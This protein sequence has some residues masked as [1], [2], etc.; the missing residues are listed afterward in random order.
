MPF[1]IAVMLYCLYHG[2]ASIVAI[3]YA[4]AILYGMQYTTVL[5]TRDT[6]AIGV[7]CSV[8]IVVCG[9]IVNKC[10]DRAKIV[11]CSVVVIVLALS[12]LDLYCQHALPIQMVL[13]VVLIG[14]VYCI[15]H[16]CNWCGCCRSDNWCLSNSIA[17]MS[18]VCI[19]G[20][21]LMQLRSIYVVWVAAIGVVIL[22]S[23]SCNVLY[24][25]QVQ[26]GYN[27]TSI[28]ISSTMQPIG[29]QQHSVVP[30][31]G[32]HQD[33]VYNIEYCIASLAKGG[34]SGDTCQVLYKDSKAYLVLSDGMGNG[35]SANCASCDTVCLIEDL[36]QHGYDIPQALRYVN[37]L[38]LSDDDMYATL[39]IVDINLNTGKVSISKNGTPTTILM[40]NRSINI[41]TSC[42]LPM[43]IITEYTPILDTMCMQSGDTIVLMSDGIFDRLQLSYLYTLLS[44]HNL[45][46]QDIAK[47]V[48]SDILTA[49]QPNDDM[50]LLLA[51]LHNNK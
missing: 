41:A 1:G 36:L 14:V 44:M 28:Q 49:V 23:V 43:G 30:V 50:T 25:L 17:L 18:I 45:T 33:T 39:D 10:V 38:M 40:S 46:L 29:L 42:N 11:K 12:T 22:L 13:N 7:A 34:V 31:V 5:Y 19:F 6:V 35:E 37:K 8:V 51:R 26:F 47:I 27:N 4:V 9:C 20:F 21:G 16:C 48:Y 15:C 32:T 24:V 3:I 2:R